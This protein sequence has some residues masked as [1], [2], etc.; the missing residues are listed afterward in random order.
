MARPFRFGVQAARAESAREWAHLA[1]KAEDLGYSTLSMPD[2]F[3][4][5]EFAPVPALAAAAAATER[6]RIG[7]LV[8][9]NDY[10]HPVV[11]A[12]EAATLDLLSEG[13]LEF[14][15]GAGWQ[16]SD[17]EASGIPY[18]DAAV[19]VE[20]FEEGL[21]VI[22]GLWSEGPLSFEGR[23]Y[24]IRELDGFPK[25]VQKP[26]PPIL[27][28]GG[29]PRVLRIAGR[30]ADIVGINVSLRQGEVTADAG[31]DATEEAILRKVGWIR[32]GAGDR[33]DQLDLNVLVFVCIVTDDRDSVIDSLGPGFGLTRDEIE[34][35]PFAL[36]GTVEQMVDTLQERRE[37]Y[38]INYVTVQ[39]DAMETF[40]PVVAK[41]AGT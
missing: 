38:G 7:S 19:R 23:H 2:H 16:R 29:S 41:L 26:H 17:Y 34:G 13:R 8:F 9:D 28:G 1:R 39:A 18:D 11:L 31:K 15:L 25:P 36:V 20:R 4:N 27:V 22:K 21:A 10:K 30:E 3:V 14:G 6:L 5:Q 32:E 12:K 33:F 40:A 24:R 35:I 37:R